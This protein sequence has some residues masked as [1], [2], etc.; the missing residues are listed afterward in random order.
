MARLL[1]FLPDNASL[2]E[3]TTRTI[4][5]RLLLTPT[6]QL[7]RIIIGALARAGR[8]YEVGVVAFSFLANHFHLLVRVKD[9]ERLASFMGFFNS[10]L[11]REVVRLTG[12]KDK[13]WSRRYQA[14]VVSNEDGA[15]AARLFYVLSNGVKENLVALCGAQE[16]TVRQA[17]HPSSPCSPEPYRG[18][19]TS[20][21]QEGGVSRRG[22]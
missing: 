15:Q 12:W 3:V 17:R 22:R 5:S 4:Q 6:P 1:R 7:N 14:I 19:I 21:T 2:V 20:V 13:V 9:A 10:K 11:A 18:R 16:G 8:R